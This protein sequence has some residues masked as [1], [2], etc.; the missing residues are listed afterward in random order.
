MSYA[1]TASPFGLGA[2]PATSTVIEKSVGSGLLSAAAF[3]GPAAPFLAIAGGIADLLAQFNVGAG[4]GQPCL[5][6]TQYANQ[7]EALLQQNIATYF[8]PP[9][10]DCSNFVLDTPR[11]QTAQAAAMANFNTI[12]NELESECGQVGGSV[13]ESCISERAAG[14]CQW[15]QPAGSV[16]PWGTP[17]EGECWNWN[18]GYLAPIQN[19]PYA[20]P[21][22]A[23]S[24]VA[25]GSVSSLIS[26]S[27]YLVLGLMAASLAAWMVLK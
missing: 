12:W 21:D 20:V 7:A 6:T 5:L 4:C 24:T 9:N 13:G 26:S 14:G 8:C 15:K 3:A 22:A 18:N 10:G 1:L 17:A 2:A 23:S 16:P 11:S 19:D 27:Q 25:G